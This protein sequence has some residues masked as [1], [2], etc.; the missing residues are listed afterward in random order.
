MVA[1][2]FAPSS[3]AEE[4]DRRNPSAF[5]HREI[6]Q[7][8]DEFAILFSYFLLNWV[9]HLGEAYLKSLFP[10]SQWATPPCQ[11]QLIPSCQTEFVICNQTIC[12]RTKLDN[13]V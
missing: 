11:L 9:P 10:Q 5:A 2:L 12:Y 1:L 7:L 8:C 3:S 13:Q 4:T 6:P